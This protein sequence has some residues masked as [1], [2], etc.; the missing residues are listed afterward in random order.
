[1][2]YLLRLSYVPFNC[3]DFR[4]SFDCSLLKDIILFSVSF[5]PVLTGSGV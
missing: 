3:S 5:L 1:M 2:R 4:V